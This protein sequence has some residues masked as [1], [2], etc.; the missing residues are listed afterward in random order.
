M[1]MRYFFIF[2]FGCLAIF[3]CGR[4]YIISEN[5]QQGQCLKNSTG[6]CKPILGVF[7]EV[8]KQFLLYLPANDQRSLTPVGIYLD[9]QRAVNTQLLTNKKLDIKRGGSLG[10]SM[11][12][13]II[14]SKT[15]SRI[16]LSSNFIDSFSYNGL[17]SKY[18]Y[19]L[20]TKKLAME[21]S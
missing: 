4:L 14:K 7:A 10:W 2:C 11:M 18:A 8:D 13:V 16:D 12:D 6:K 20:Y 15:D 21:R 19:N 17:N 5:G 9:D 3:V 1:K